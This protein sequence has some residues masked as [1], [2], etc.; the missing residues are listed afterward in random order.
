M[1]RT[2]IKRVIKAIKAEKD[3]RFDMTNWGGTHSCGTAACIAGFS[4]FLTCKVP[5]KDICA[6][7]MER[8]A[9]ENFGVNPWQGHSIF[10]PRCLDCIDKD[11]AIEFLTW[12]LEQPKDILPES[13]DRQWRAMIKE[14]NCTV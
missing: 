14:A 9:C 4:V 12:L 7:N 13:I 5:F 8:L 2:H 10:V 3:L 6:R 1:N 11:M